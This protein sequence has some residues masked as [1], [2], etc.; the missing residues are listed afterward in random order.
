MVSPKIMVSWWIN[1]VQICWKLHFFLREF[2]G[3]LNM[4]FSELG[5]VKTDVFPFSNGWRSITR[6][7]DDSWLEK[8]PQGMNSVWFR[9]FLT[10]QTAGYKWQWSISKTWTSWTVKVWFPRWDLKFETQWKLCFH[11]LVMQNSGFFRQFSRISRKPL[12]LIFFRQGSQLPP[13][14][15]RFDAGSL[16]AFDVAPPGFPGIFSREVV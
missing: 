11:I 3:D 12:P 15:R 1:H 16:D 5:G 13:W 10:I 4:I 9:E 7:F 2:N 6:Y 14:P 8:P